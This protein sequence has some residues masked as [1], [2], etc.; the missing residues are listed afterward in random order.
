MKLSLFYRCQL[1]V[2][3]RKRCVT[4]NLL[5]LSLSYRFQ[6]RV[7][8]RKCCVTSNHPQIHYDFV[9]IYVSAERKVIR[10]VINDVITN[11]TE[12]RGMDTTLD[13]F[14]RKINS[15]LLRGVDISP[16]NFVR[17][18]NSILPPKHELLPCDFV[19]KLNFK[20]PHQKRQSR[21]GTAHILTS[22]ILFYFSIN[23]I[24]K[25]PPITR[26]ISTFIVTIIPEPIIPVIFI[27]PTSLLNPMCIALSL[28]SFFN[29]NLHF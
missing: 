11:Y 18:I 21:Q 14:I 9:K 4:S 1:R 26:L 10:H 12:P 19:Q 7:T 8:E 16:N 15:I 17:K 25:H 24:A 13:D 23:F 20:Y 3:K 22:S 29:Y 27:T 5:K 28:F 6:L 2:V